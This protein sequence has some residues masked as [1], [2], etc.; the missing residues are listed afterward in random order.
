MNVSF[1][2]ESKKSG[3]SPLR[4]LSNKSAHNNASRKLEHDFIAGLDK[5]KHDD[6]LLR[7]RLR[8]NDKSFSSSSS[9][10]S[11]PEDET[12]LKTLLAQSKSRLENTDALR[13]RH[14]LL[15]PE[16][17]V[18]YENFSMNCVRA[19]GMTERS[20]NVFEFVNNEVMSERRNKENNSS[21]PC[22]TMN[23]CLS[24]HS[25]SFR[26]LQEDHVVFVLNLFGFV[27]YLIE[28]LSDFLN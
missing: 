26:N 12:E 28:F 20:E 6:N 9:S 14:H 24:E 5:R 8:S 19:N 11:E 10:G 21:D 2:T 25:F 3:D 22:D 15:R 18:R 23:K 1:F 13:I 17:Y 16:D 4:R 7:R 27:A